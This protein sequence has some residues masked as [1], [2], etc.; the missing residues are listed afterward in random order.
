VVVRDVWIGKMELSALVIGLKDA[1]V[2]MLKLMQSCN[3]RYSVLEVVLKDP[4]CFQ[5]IRLVWNVAK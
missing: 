4:H 5:H 1:F 3:V 2:L